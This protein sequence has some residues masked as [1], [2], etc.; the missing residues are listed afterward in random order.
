MSN[1]ILLDLNYLF[2]LL[3]T[4]LFDLFLTNKSF[5]KLKIYKMCSAFFKHFLIL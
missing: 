5:K 2:L 3:L 1:S 4:I